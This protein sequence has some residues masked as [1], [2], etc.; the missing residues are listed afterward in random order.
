MTTT[1]Q[2]IT[3]ACQCGQT[4]DQRRAALLETLQRNLISANKVAAELIKLDDAG[5][6][7]TSV[8]HKAAS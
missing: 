1:P 6:D 3:P 5:R 2:P 4:D 7:A 8:T